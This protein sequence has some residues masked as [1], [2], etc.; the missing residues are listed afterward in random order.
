MCLSHFNKTS[1]RRN[2]ACES[3]FKGSL[4][5]RV[6]NAAARMDIYAKLVGCSDEELTLETSSSLSFFR[7]HLLRK[8]KTFLSKDV[9]NP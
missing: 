5:F 4:K 7:F 6:Q 9:T 1:A 8:K 3:L 2:S